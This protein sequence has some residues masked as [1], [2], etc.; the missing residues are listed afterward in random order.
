MPQ[1][2]E[3]KALTPAQKINVDEG[4]DRGTKY[5]IAGEHS[6]GAPHVP[7]REIRRPLGRWDGV[8]CPKAPS[9]LSRHAISLVVALLLAAY[10]PRAFAQMRV[11]VVD[12]Q[13]AMSETE[14]GRRARRRLKRLFDDRQAELE[15]RQQEL[16]QLANEAQAPGLSDEARRA[17]AE[18][19]QSKAAE[20]QQ[21][22]TQ[23]QREV[24]EKEAELTSPI[25]RRMEQ[26]LRQLGQA[27][28]YALIVERSQGG[29][30]FVPTNLDL[31]DVV[32]QRY[33]AGEG[34]EDAASAERSPRDTPT[35]EAS[36]SEAPPR[37]GEATRRRRDAG[38]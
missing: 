13:R 29:V 34:R 24:A 12:L 2:I 14:D 16:K 18:T 33:E 11:A 35:S 22:Y 27:E 3:A 7:W 25:V 21:L 19:L 36:R 30:V 26:I 31:T 10:A 38:P 5:G 8:N 37:S 23:Y 1:P 17:Q 28:G 6:P 4:L 9:W 32:I 20:L 15:R